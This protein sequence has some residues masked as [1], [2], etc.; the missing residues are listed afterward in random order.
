MTGERAEAEG[1][2]CWLGDSSGRGLTPRPG[3]LILFAAGC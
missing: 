2:Y 1:T 3:R